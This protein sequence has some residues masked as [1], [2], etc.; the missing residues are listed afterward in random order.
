MQIIGQMTEREQAMFVDCR[1]SGT[2]KYLTNIDENGRN[3]NLK[4]KI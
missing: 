4:S 3:K 2:K 1:S